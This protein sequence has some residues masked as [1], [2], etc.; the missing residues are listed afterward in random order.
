MCH[1][2]DCRDRLRLKRHALTMLQRLW[3][4]ILSPYL[5]TLPPDTLSK[6]MIE[7]DFQGLLDVLEFDNHPCEC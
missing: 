7:R 3:T 4:E 2:G 1:R 5:E 6:K